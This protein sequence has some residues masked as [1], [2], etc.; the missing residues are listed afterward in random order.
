ML[1]VVW[2]LTP[3]GKS[4][5]IRA[6]ALLLVPDLEHEARTR[7]AME[8]GL[9]VAMESSLALKCKLFRAAPTL[10]PDRAVRFWV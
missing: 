3:Q 1:C 5:D 4:R 2:L 9:R 10:P 7:K 6:T 8:R